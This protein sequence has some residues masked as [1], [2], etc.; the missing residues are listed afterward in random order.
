MFHLKPIKLLAFYLSLVIITLLSFSAHSQNFIE[1]NKLTALDRAISD[2][3]GMYA[4]A[5]EGNIAF[6]GAKLED[7]DANGNNPKTDAGSVYIY[8]RDNTGNWS[9]IQKI[10]ASD[11]EVNDQFGISVSISGNYAVI[12]TRY[13]EGDSLNTNFQPHTGSA[14]IFERQPN[15]LWLEKQEIVS[16]N[17]MRHDDFGSSVSISGGYIII[18][19]RG[20]SFDL[21]QSAHLSYSGAA[22]IFEQNTSG[23]WVQKQKLISPHREYHGYY[24]GS[25][26]ISGNYIVIGNNYYSNNQNGVYLVERIGN[27]LWINKQQLT[28]SSNQINN[29][30]GTSVSISGNYLII[31]A[32]INYGAAY[33]FKKDNQG[34]WAETQKIIASDAYEYGYFGNSVSISGNRAIVGSFGQVSN[35]LGIDSLNKAGAAYIFQLNTNGQW[36]EQ[37]KIVASDRNPND[38][39]GFTVAISDE[40]AIVGSMNDLDNFGGNTLFNAGAAYVFETPPCLISDSSFSVIECD[41][42]TVPSSK[43]TYST[44]GNYVVNDTIPNQ[45]GGDSILNIDITILPSQEST[46]NSTICFGDTIMVNG[47]AYHSTNTTGIE[48]ISN[49]GPYNCD[50]T[51]TVNLNVLPQKKSAISEVLCLNDSIVVNGVIYNSNNLSGTEIFHNVGPY[52]CDS[53]VLINLSIYTSMVTTVDPTGEVCTNEEVQITTN[54]K[55]GKPPYS[56][57]WTYGNITNTDILFNFI[58]LIDG[59]DFVSLV[60]QDNCNEPEYLTLPFILNNCEIIIPNIITPNGDGVNDYF[61]IIGLN[62]NQNINIQ[63]FNRWGTSVFEQDNYLNNWDAYSL[64]DGVYFYSLEITGTGESLNYSGPLTILK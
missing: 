15:G 11:R 59:D 40:Y 28:P 30:Y 9:Q 60:I 13:G 32:Q 54:V 5:I 45:C 42:F 48:K 56:Y 37:Q 34:N 29:A 64:P 53:T 44:P 51:I 16:I 57:L 21:N 38:E 2:R 1:V 31:S 50:S 10:V 49:V 8:Q 22:Y 33:I 52:N 26:S 41:S 7:D 17:G 27:G 43:I 23:Y 6:V 19:A 47:T 46:I 58:P 3:M 18:G 39:F 62:P 25:V 36:V 20:N 55:E 35:S 24:G 12:G 4:L 14:Y 63:V 61:Q